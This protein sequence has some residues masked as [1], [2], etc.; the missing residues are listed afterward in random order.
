ME[1]TTS[2][3]VPKRPAAAVRAEDEQLAYLTLSRDPP[4][5]L[6]PK[7]HR[8]VYIL[9]LPLDQV[10]AWTEVQSIWESVQSDGEK[11]NL[12]RRKVLRVL[13]SIPPASG[14][15]VVEPVKSLAVMHMFTEVLRRAGK[16]VTAETGD[17]FVGVAVTVVTK[18][19]MTKKAMLVVLVSGI[20]I[21]KQSKIQG[22]HEAM[23]RIAEVYYRTTTQD[24]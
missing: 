18:S 9:A 6:G 10:V 17:H 14:D 5:Q 15:T 1:A 8:W 20:E 4:Q 24:T 19:V 2:K 12:P 21:L 3:V 23:G 16:G 11:L 22:S 13:Q 7:C